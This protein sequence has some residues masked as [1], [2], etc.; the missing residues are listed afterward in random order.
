MK[1]HF[2]KFLYFLTMKNLDHSFSKAKN[3]LHSQ[4]VCVCVWLQHFHISTELKLNSYLSFEV[5]ENIVICNL[6]WDFKL[7]RSLNETELGHLKI[8][9][10][11]IS[12]LMGQGNTLKA[13]TW[14][15][16]MI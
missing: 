12:I 8:V 5:Y 14:N 15:G 10:T 16:L 13:E 4:N 6:F 1:T 11:F 7:A 3:E 9:T 2:A